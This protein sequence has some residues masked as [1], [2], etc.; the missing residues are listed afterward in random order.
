[1]HR[2]VAHKRGGRQ[3]VNGR[4]KQR[5]Q[6]RRRSQSTSDEHSSDSGETTRCVCGETRKV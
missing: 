4:R 2:L 6:P 1:M 3:G 5:T